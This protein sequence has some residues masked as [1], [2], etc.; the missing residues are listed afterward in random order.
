MKLSCC[1][2]LG[3]VTLGAIATVSV[4]NVSAQQQLPPPPI[5]G[6]PPTAMPLPSTP[7]PPSSSFPSYPSTP[8]I[9]ASNER[10]YSA[11][12]NAG[13]SY[14][15]SYRVI[16][17]STDPSVLQRVR[18]AKP[19]AF[20]QTLNGRRVIQAGIFN[21]EVNAQQMVTLLANQGVSSGIVSGYNSS[22]SSGEY[23]NG[24]IRMSPQVNSPRGYYAIVP[25]NQSE[26]SQ[27]RLRA[28]Q[29]GVPSNAVYLRN[30]P[31][32]PHM[33]IGPYSNRRDAEKLSDYLRNPG[34]LDS[35]VYFTK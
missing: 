35:R 21:R 9:P 3:A 23:N 14:Y 33:A 34:R 26:L 27:L 32:G 13:Q 10:I 31:L 5:T 6:N 22:V 11:P 12:G 24:V 30:S 1:G 15:G 17:D 4:G 20:F 16:V 7:P 18:V 29:L 25:G 8:S 28:T 2:K 19:D